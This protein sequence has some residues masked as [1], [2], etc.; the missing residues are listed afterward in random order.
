MKLISLNAKVREG[1]GRTRSRQLRSQGLIPAVF[2]GESG[3]RHLT[4]NVP[5]L[6]AAWKKIAGSASLI[7]LKVEGDDDTH[8]ALIQEAQR[9]PRTDDFI[10]LDFKEIV[11]GREM[12]AHIPIHTFGSP[13]GVRHYGGVLEVNLSD[14]HVRCRP[15]NLPEFIEVDVSELEI[16]K[17]IHLEELTAPEGVEFLYDPELVVASCVGASSGAAS[18]ADDEEA[19][20]GEGA[21][22]SAE[23]ADAEATEEETAKA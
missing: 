8:F 10:H 7:E 19:E 4:L 11:R 18:P 23:E 1:L 21:E 22:E 2:Y 17:S 16:G 20:E 5:E 6:L 3:V 9:N 14:V 13:V 15:R 12:E